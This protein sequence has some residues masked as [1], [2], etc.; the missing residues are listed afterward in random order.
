MTATYT[1]KRGDIV[2]LSLDPAAGREQNKRRPALVLSPEKFQRAT[3]LALVAPIT[4]TVR[5][6]GFEVALGNNAKTAGVA[7]CHQIKMLDFSAREC[8]FIEKCP[9]AAVKEALLKVIVLLQ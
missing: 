2:W 1:P 5:G 7:L 8:T 6:I 3:G 4:S 9:P